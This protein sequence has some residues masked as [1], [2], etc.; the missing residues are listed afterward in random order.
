MDCS[1]IPEPVAGPIEVNANGTGYALT[2]SNKLVSV[3]FGD[4][5]CLFSDINNDLSRTLK[6]KEI[7][8]LKNLELSESIA[9]TTDE[10]LVIYDND[11][12]ITHIDRTNSSLRTNIVTSVQEI[13]K[14]EILIGS[15]LGLDLAYKTDFTIIDRFGIEDFPEA[16]GITGTEDGRFFVSSYDSVFSLDI[17]TSNTQLIP[18]FSLDGNAGISSL[19]AA[20]DHVYVGTTNGQIL[21]FDPDNRRVSCRYAPRHTQASGPITAVRINAV[22]GR[23]FATSLDTQIYFSSACN[24]ES[25][26]PLQ[27]F[28]RLESPTP[29]IG[30]ALFGF[31]VGILDL[32]GAHI[33]KASSLDALAPITGQPVQPFTFLK[34]VW[35]I[36]SDEEAS[37]FGRPDGDVFFSSISRPLDHKSAFSLEE[38]LYSLEL[39]KSGRAWMATKSGLSVFSQQNGTSAVLSSRSIRDISL[40]YNVSFAS[41]DGRLV[42][43]GSGGIVI[44]HDPLRFPHRP[45]GRIRLTKISWGENV[46]TG[47]Q[48]RLPLELSLTPNDSDLTIRIQSSSLITK[49]PLT[50]QT[51]LLPI[52]TSW[53]STAGVSDFPIGKLPP[54]NYTFQARGADALGIWSENEISIPITVAGSKWESRWARGLYVAVAIAVI[55]LA[56]NSAQRSAIRRHRQVLADEDRAAVLRLEDECQE[57]RESTDRILQ[58]ITP[59][60]VS[61]LDV[62]K[63]LVLAHQS[64]DSGEITAHGVRAIDQKFGALRSQVELSERSRGGDRCNLRALVDETFARLSADDGAGADCLLLNDA[65][66]IDVPVR[67]AQY[68]A[69]SLYELLSLMINAPGSSS[70]TNPVFEI[71]LDSPEAADVDEDG[72]VLRASARTKL[73]FDE[74]ELERWLPVTMQII[75]DFGGNIQL[76]DTM[77]LEVELHLNLN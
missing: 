55:L 44:I 72:Y 37:F 26:L 48:L 76:K 12:S 54:G 18:L 56:W 64:G 14:G 36:A 58:S 19:Y 2:A 27:R 8:N 73:R 4:R 49:S 13:A 29:I 50:L 43:G 9:I 41:S 67:H 16:T 51:R 70:D 52:N 47:K 53:S 60:L 15:F 38:T 75:E 39:D 32:K 6:T 11:Q 45:S 62:A 20:A 57:Q 1:G 21:A 66:D 35:L 63:E 59:T 31:D 69:L 30:L 24:T 23:L 68:L 46:T 7:R 71:A 34:D 61:L 10:G 33:F 40:D 28:A 65:Q 3:S 74:A 25:H 17:G 5:E 77:G 42:F 22:S